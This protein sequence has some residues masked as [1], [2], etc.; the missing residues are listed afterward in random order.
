MDEFARRFPDAFG[1]PCSSGRWQPARG[2]LRQ[3]IGADS[4]ALCVAAGGMRRCFSPKPIWYQVAHAHR[5]LLAVR[6]D[7]QHGSGVSSADVPVGRTGPVRDSV[8]GRSDCRGLPAEEEEN[9]RISLAGFSWTLGAD[10]RTSCAAL[11]RCCRPTTGERADGLVEELDRYAPQ[12][13]DHCDLLPAWP[14]SVYRFS[15][16]DLLARPGGDRRSRDRRSTALARGLSDGGFSGRNGASKLR[17]AHRWAGIDDRPMGGLFDLLLLP[18]REG[19]RRRPE[20]L[21]WR[22]LRTGVPALDAG[23]SR[24]GKHPAAL[25]IHGRAPAGGLAAFQSA[26]AEPCVESR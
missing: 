23:S 17:R 11:R 4:R 26:E 5:G 10:K 13:I 24:L 18:A 3:W 12:V 25:S 7:P 14:R 22:V 2:P 21:L 16:N 6:L 20:R 8:V 1:V 9:H 19:V 15:Q